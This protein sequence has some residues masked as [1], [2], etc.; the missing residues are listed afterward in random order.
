MDTFMTVFIV[1][2]VIF[3]IVL[4]PFAIKRRGE[5]LSG[6]YGERKVSEFIEDLKE[7]GEILINNYLASRNRKGTDSIQIDH[8]FI[9]HKGVF[10]IET[11]DY[12]GRIYG[13]KYQNTWTQTIGYKRIQKNK[14][15]NPIK[16]NDTHTRYV[17][18]IVGGYA[19]FYNVV[20]FL[21]ADISR[22]SNSSD[23]LFDPYS[24]A[25][26]YRH[27]Q[28]NCLSDSMINHINSVL[29]DEMNTHPI[30]KE[31]HIS[32]IHRRHGE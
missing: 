3:V 9:S 7:E 20:I 10:V 27:L 14:L 32:N 1:F 5:R 6:E 26:W 24:F 22:V 13:D 23:V 15:Y 28:N 8:I 4:L 31:E 11:K 12:R 18:R 30:T 25:N 19:P 2:L 16:Q 29:L 17:Q 21:K